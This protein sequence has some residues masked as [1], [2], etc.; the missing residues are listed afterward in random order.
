MSSEPAAVQTIEDVAA[1]L[2]DYLTAS[3]GQ[4]GLSFHPDAP[5]AIDD[6]ETFLEQTLQSSALKE[7]L[8]PS[9]DD[10]PLDLPSLKGLFLD[11][12][13]FVP[14]TEDAPFE[15]SVV[16]SWHPDHSPVTAN[17]PAGMTFALERLR[18]TIDLGGPAPTVTLDGVMTFDGLTLDVSVQLP[19]LV[20]E[21]SLQETSATDGEQSAAVGKYV[22]NGASEQPPGGG[23]A[24]GGM[25]LHGLDLMAALSAERVLLHFEVDDL[26]TFP[27]FTLD[28]VQVDMVYDGRSGVS[29]RLW[30]ELEIGGTTD[31]PLVV[32]ALLAERS[33]EGQWDFEG[34][35]AASGVYL[36]DLLE[37]LEGVFGMDGGSLE[38]PAAMA[39]LEIVDL[40]LAYSTGEKCF[41]F[42]IDIEIPVEPTMLDASISISR[43]SEPTPVT[44]VSAVLRLE[45]D[46]ATGGAPP[47]LHDAAKALGIGDGFPSVTVDKGAVG[48]QTLPRAD[49]VA[50]AW[51]VG[52]Q[53]G[54]DLE[55]SKGAEDLHLPQV[56]QLFKHDLSFAIR[57]VE[58]LLT[59]APIQQ[60]ELADV[61][62]L[63]GFTM[64]PGDLEEVFLSAEVELGE[65]TYLV[66]PASL[67]VDAPPAGPPARPG[68]V[69]A[70]VG[71]SSPAAA[72]GVAGGD[73]TWVTLHKQISLLYLDKVGV[74]Y[75]DGKL[76]LAVSAS[77]TAS[78]LTL[79]L[80]GFT[81]ESP[82]DRFAPT[83][84]LTGLGVSYKSSSV[85][86]SGAFL[87]TT[88]PDGSA[89]FTGE[90]SIKA[91]TWS[92]GAFGS[93]AS[94]D[95]N[96]S[97]FIYAFLDTPL[98]GPSFCFV[99][100]LA[101]GF[102]YNRSLTVPP[103]EELASFPLVSAAMGQAPA[104]DDPSDQ[105][106]QALQSLNA[107]IQPDLGENW[108]A[109]GLRF[110]SFE[111][112]Q[113]FALLTVSFGSSTEIDIL[114][115]SSI[116]MPT[117]LPAGQDPVGFAQMALRVTFSP[118]T[119]VLAAQGLLTPDSFILSKDCHLTG[120]FAFS[121]WFMGQE[122][123]DFVV[124]QGGYHPRFVKPKHY[125]DAPPVGFN[126]QVGNLTIKGGMYF[127]LTPG[128]VMAGGFLD[129]V[130]Q[131]GDI[132]AWFQASADFL[133]SWKPFH[134]DIA[135]SIS[136]GASFRVNLL[137]TS[138]TMT[139]HVGVD[140]ALA[141]PPF[142]GSATVDLSVVS[143]TI[144]LGESA[145]P[146]EAISWETFR[147][148]F[149]PP[150]C[151][152]D[153]A[154]D[155]WTAHRPDGWP[156]PIWTDSYCTARVT[157][158]LVRD[159]TGKPPADSPEVD[160]PTWIVNGTTF[161]LSVDVVIPPATATFSSGDLAHRMPLPAK[162]DPPVGVD[163]G[164]VGIEAKDFESDLLVIVRNIRDGSYRFLDNVSVTPTFASV[165]KALWNVTSA[166]ETTGDSLATLSS[167]GLID[168]TLKGFTFAANEP[169][170]HNTLP[171]SI[172][173]VQREQVRGAKASWAR[174][175]QDRTFSDGESVAE[176]REMVIEVL[177]RQSGIEHTDRR[178]VA[179]DPELETE[180]VV[181]ALGATP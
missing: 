18:A 139:I 24:P 92:L 141:G 10:H 28:A 127:A 91:A 58:V 83:F 95:G 129:A 104:G 126:W 114:G 146:K 87:K 9:T 27:P 54:F 56:Q 64:P 6:A 32:L 134:Y 40:S 53:L 5:L 155:L 41:A 133:L 70:P 107:Y 175:D 69:A 128:A 23:P 42:A 159:L 106:T 12:L 153:P 52:T 102:G 143:F 39:R 67:S 82:L 142:G 109:I 90:A 115:L 117:Q 4:V 93:Y 86:V 81:I 57:S 112:I 108:L 63:D 84:G 118:A 78:G 49:G 74:R 177:A 132:S 25:S 50:K 75:Q 105:T 8:G 130:W 65:T 62:A 116:T 144:P 31:N 156:A 61:R 45:A 14:G 157:G 176:R 13:D 140:L 135:V 72:P 79:T 96:A 121:A 124:T 137:F 21:A 174:A 29:G 98:G 145:H 169:V 30:T 99:T 36:G 131:S 178:A 76:M 167:G 94:V 103:I 181:C 100:G 26:I 16:V 120:G 136:I 158:G 172:A 66:P 46:A 149:L 161:E 51:V 148:S 59:T 162:G 89:E 17:G 35:L 147:E 111:V 43:T 122:A 138:F 71:P 160:P 44:T 88:L 47:D 68:S 164:P 119:G 73:I 2:G 163:A 179:D 180:P 77:V 55:L 150:I 11:S 3:D 97:V 33:T 151:A 152:K 22:L 37:A 171:V 60:A 125:P 113:S 34:R 165:P 101:A 48:Y 85:E 15:L 80:D 20:F 1:A 110:T 154:N 173:D 168:R 7:I 166:M 19:A 170:P 123:G 38:L